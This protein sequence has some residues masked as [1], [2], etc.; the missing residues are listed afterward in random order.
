MKCECPRECTGSGCK[1]CLAQ[2]VD[3]AWRPM[4][5]RDLPQF[6]WWSVAFLCIRR[7][8][9]RYNY[10]HHSEFLNVLINRYLCVTA[11]HGGK[12]LDDYLLWR[13]R[14]SQS[15]SVTCALARA[16]ISLSRLLLTSHLPPCPLLQRT[17][18]ALI[19]IK[20]ECESDSIAYRIICCVAFDRET[21]ASYTMWPM[22][23]DG[24]FFCCKK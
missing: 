20:S 9:G 15:R 11:N 13:V 19:F 10:I 14:M 2:V 12:S 6:V 7:T 23:C 16:S 3:V 8:G 17:A 24:V 4:Y 22:V 18:Y 21:V 5:C 1:P